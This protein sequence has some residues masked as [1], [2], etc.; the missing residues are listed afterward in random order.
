MRDTLDQPDGGVR[1][2]VL[3]TKM[4]LSI[5]ALLRPVAV[6]LTGL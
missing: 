4:R 1:R 5:E 3:H 6:I 2:D